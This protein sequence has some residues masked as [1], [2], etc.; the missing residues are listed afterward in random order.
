MTTN[1]V[2]EDVFVMDGILVGGSGSGG[3]MRL[4]GSSSDTSGGFSSSGSNSV[5]H[6][7]EIC[8]SWEDSSYCRHGPKCQVSLSHTHTHNL[9]CFSFIQIINFAIFCW[10][11]AIQIC[12]FFGTYGLDVSSISDQRYSHRCPDIGVQKSLAEL[13]SAR[14]PSLAPL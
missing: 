14:V 9:V 1:K 8:R 13:R 2:E 4:S 3:R 10:P 12:H 6:K 11:V 5:V 7:R